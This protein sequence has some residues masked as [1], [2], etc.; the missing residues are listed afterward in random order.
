MQ[1]SDE[2]PKKVK[3]KFKQTKQLVKTA[4]GEGWTQKQIADACRTQQSVVS[5]WASGAK[6]GTEEQLKPL[7]EQ[8]GNKIR[9]NSFRLYQTIENGAAVYHKVEGRIIF[10]ET[11]ACNDRNCR[12]K[13]RHSKVK[14]TIHDQGNGNLRLISQIRMSLEPDDGS[15]RFRPSRCDDESQIWLSHIYDAMSAHKILEIIDDLEKKH[16]YE[17]RESA[18]MLRFAIRESLLLN[19]Y[20][21]EGIV[22]YPAKW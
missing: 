19:G 6:L 13:R 4:L 5:A 3:R 20:P 7:L 14:F 12:K 16:F 22:D 1:T 8:F 2:K 18:W 9:R 17:Y 10:S 15:I 21:V 11:L